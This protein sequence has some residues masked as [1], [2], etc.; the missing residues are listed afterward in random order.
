MTPLYYLSLL[1]SAALAFQ[2]QVGIMQSFHLHRTTV[3]HTLPNNFERAQHCATHYGSCS[4]EE[5]EELA[6][7]TLKKS[8]SSL[9]RSHHNYAPLSVSVSIKQSIIARLMSHTFLLLLLLL[10][11]LSLRKYRA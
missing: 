8:I 5:M 7:G 2:Q 10:R 3:L 11:L 9:L 6:S 1:P 4:L